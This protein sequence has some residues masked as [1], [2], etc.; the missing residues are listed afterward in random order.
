MKKKCLSVLSVLL[1]LSLLLGGC[2]AKTPG[3]TPET[4]GG[5]EV[6]E[7]PTVSLASPIL[8]LWFSDKIPVK[9]FS[10]EVIDDGN[11]IRI[12]KYLGSETA[13]MI[14]SEIDGKPVTAVAELAFAEKEILRVMI[15]ASVTEINEYAFKDCTLLNYVVFAGDAPETFDVDRTMN[16]GNSRFDVY[17]G[18][19][20]KGFEPND[21][22]EEWEWEDR[23]CKV[24]DIEEFS[25]PF[26]NSTVKSAA[27]TDDELQEGLSRIP[28]DRYEIYY[29]GNVYDH[30][31]KPESATLYKD[32][33]AITIDP[34]DPRLIQLLNF[35]NNAI[36]Y[37]NY[38]W[39]QGQTDLEKLENSSYRL[40]LTYT[41]KKEYVTD[42]LI[43]SGDEF[44]CVKSV[45]NETGEEERV[46]YGNFPYFSVPRTY[47]WLEFFGF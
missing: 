34:N 32:G 26:C 27:L 29:P 42:T 45:L 37:L 17:H 7:G 20:A 12:T 10:Y 46:A 4:T 33:E 14:P 15:P 8:L 28:S 38:G 22:E 31:Y 40:V 1:L 41:P 19:M 39:T 11:A 13:V 18:P 23:Y 9:D 6:V 47:N 2:A 44:G 43:V 24:W 25:L 3:D 36:Y 21:G 35:Y 16:A 30:F 5:Q